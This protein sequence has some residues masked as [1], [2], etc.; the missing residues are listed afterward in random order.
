[1][2]ANTTST[3][4][5]FT[6]G[7]IVLPVTTGPAVTIP[8]TILNPIR[9]PII[10]RPQN[11][12]PAWF[13]SA[14][15]FL[16]QQYA[17][18]SNFV[19]EF[20]SYLVGS[21]VDPYASLGSTR[22]FII[23]LTRNIFRL[24]I[25]PDIN[26]L[27]S[28]NL[29][30]ST[31]YA[32]T[33]SGI[34]SMYQALAAS[35]I[36]SSVKFCYIPGFL[37]KGLNP[38]ADQTRSLD[39]GYDPGSGLRTCVLGSA[40]SQ[41]V[42]L[43]DFST[44][45]NEEIF[46]PSPTIVPFV[47]ALVYDVNTNNSLNAKT[48]V[49]PTYYT[50][51][52]I[53]SNYYVNKLGSNQSLNG[54]SVNCGQTVLF[55]GGPG[56]VA[57]NAVS[58]TLQ[59]TT[60]VT[61]VDYTSTTYVFSTATVVTTSTSTLSP[62]V[63]LGVLSLTY[64]GSSPSTVFSNQNITGFYQDSTWSTCRGI[65][66][67]DFG[68]QNASFAPSLQT[69][70][71][72]P[73]ALIYDPTSPFL[74]GGP[75]PLVL[76]KIFI[77][78]Y[79]YPPDR[80]VQ[81]L[82]QAATS[83]SDTRAAA[84]GLAVQTAALDF[85]LTSTPTGPILDHLTVP[86]SVTVV[87]TP[88]PI[89]IPIR[90]LDDLKSTTA[91]SVKVPTI[92]VDS[93][94]YITQLGPSTVQ[95]GLNASIPVEAL[96]GTG[97]TT[98]EIGTRFLQQPLGQGSAIE[99]ISAAGAVINL[100]KDTDVSPF[101]PY[102]LSIANASTRFSVGVYY[103]LS[104]SGANLTVR[105]SDGSSVS[106][107]ISSPP[108][109]GHTYVG[110]VVYASSITAVVLYAKLQ[111]TLLSPAVG[112]HG[113]LQDTK[114]SVHLI[115][116]QGN[117]TYDIVDSTLATV[118][119]SI[120]VPSPQATDGS[121]PL[122]N[123]LYFGSFVGGSSQMTV[124]SVPV[125]LT[126][127]PS[128][129]S[130]ASF[131]GGMVL[132]SVASGLPS[133]Q[134]QITDSSLFI[135]SNIN[136]DSESIGS[137]SSSNV[138]LAS[139]VINS[140]PDDRSAQAYAPNKLLMGLVRQAQVGSNN[141]YVFVPED[142]SVVI[143]GIRYM[144]S[145]ISLGEVP[146]FSTLQYPLPYLPVYWP[147]AQY[148]QF[149]SKHNPY[150]DVQYTGSTQNERIRTAQTDTIRIGL[151]TANAQEPIHMYLDTDPTLM[152]VYPI[153]AFPFLKATN[154]IDIGQLS[155]ITSTI[156]KILSTTFPP[157]TPFVPSNLDKERI[158]I[159]DNL[160]L[161]NPYI[162]D[163][164]TTIVTNPPTTDT[165]SITA[166]D[167]T[168]VIVGLQVSNLA[169]NTL[170]QT[171][172]NT[173]QAQQN[174][175]TK[176][177]QTTAANQAV[178]KITTSVPNVTQ[179]LDLVP[180]KLLNNSFRHA[181]QPV[182]G[183]SVYNAGSGEAY[184]IEVVTSNDSIPDVLPHP[185]ANANYDPYYV[186]VVFLN[187]LTAYNMSIIVPSMVYDENNV[188]ATQGVT[189]QNVLSQTDEFP[190]GYVS[191][192]YD[193]N[194]NFDTLSF[195]PYPPVANPIFGG[196]DI[197]L[198]FHLSQ[199]Q[200][201]LF[202]STPYSLGQLAIYNP[203]SLFENV[204]SQ[205]PATENSRLENFINL[206][207]IQFIRP[208]TPPAYFVCRR[209]NWKSEC[210]LMQA[211]HN[212]G[213]AAY[214][215]F[216]AGDIVP[217][218]LTSPSPISI[219]HRLPAFNR[220]LTFPFA[221]KQYVAAQV[222]SVGNVP[223]VIASSTDGTAVQFS[224]F[225]LSSTDGTLDVSNTNK[226]VLS[227]PSEIY[228]VGQA[229]T[230][231]T[232]VP[233][234]TGVFNLPDLNGNLSAF[235]VVT[236]NNLVYL[237]RAVSNIPPQYGL[238]AIGGIG[239]FAGLLIDTY[240][241][242]ID[243]ALGL[244]QGA[245]HKRSGLSFFGSMYTPTTMVES[246]D[247]LDYT[248]ITGNTFYA[249]TMFI[250]IPE[251]DSMKGFVADLSNFLGQQVWTFIYPEIV[252]L[253]GDS[254]NGVT[255]KDGYN[256]DNNKKPILSLQKLHF[257]YDSIAV[258]FTSNDLTHKYTLQP[259]QQVLALTNDQII[260]GI[261]WRSANVQVD[262]DP[263]TNVCA[264]QILSTGIGYDRPNIIYSPVN[265]P[266]A[267]SA[268]PSYQG[269]SV[270][271]F[272][273]MSGTTYN[274]EERKLATKLSGPPPDQ[275]GAKYINSVSSTKNM[276]IGVLFDYDNNDQGTMTTYDSGTSTKGLAFLNGYQSSNGYTFSS[277]DHFDVND[278]LKSQ[279]PLLEEI[280]NNMQQDQAFFNTDL[281]LPRQYWSLTYDVFTAAGLPNYIATAPP[282]LIDPNFTN[283]T[284]S[285]ILSLQN[286]QDPVQP[287]EI[288]L[289]DT[290]SSVVSVNLHLQNGIT[291]SIFLNKTADRDIAY[292]SSPSVPTGSVPPPT[293]WIGSIFGLPANYDFF[294]FSRDHYSTLYGAA[295]QVIDNGYAMCLMD[296]GTGTGNK[297]AKYYVDS[298]GNYFESYS[299]VLSSLSNGIVETSSFILKVTLGSPANLAATP[300]IPETPNNISPQDMVNAI[301][302]ASNVVY[303]A[304]GP[305]S[306]GQPPAYI[307][308][309]AVGTQP[310]ALPII[311]PPGFNGYQ[312]NVSAANRQPVQISQIYSGA[313]AYPI[314]GSTA[315][316]PLN[317]A[318]NFVPFYGS[319][320]H[321]LD[322]Q[323]TVFKSLQ[324]ADPYSFIPRGAIP[325]P[326]VVGGAGTGSLIG[327]EFRLC[328]QG[329]AAIPPT[330]S[331]ST[332]AG[333][334]ME[335][336]DA[337]FYTYNAV[338]ATIF[339]S[340]GKS[341]SVSGGQYFV[342]TVTTQEPIY[343]AITLPT[344]TFNGNTYTVNI[345]TT[346]MDGVTSLYTLVVG[347]KS[348]L[349]DSGNK[350]VTTDQTKFT[351]N[352]VTSGA[353]TVTYT[354]IDTPSGNIST[355]PTP[356]LLSPF[357]VTG[358]GRVGGLVVDVFNSPGQ[359]QN[360]I[361]GITGR[362]YSYDPVHA[363]VTITQGSTATTVP[364]STGSI[365]ASS[366]GYGYVIQFTTVPNVAGQ[367][368]AVNGAIMFKY[369][370]ML[371]SSP[372]PYNLMTTPKMFTV[373]GDHYTFD[374]DSAGNYLT[375]TGNNQTI[376]VNPYQFSILGEIYIINTQTTPN[377]VIGGGQTYKMTASNTQ[378]I[379]NGVQYTIS[380]LKN[381]LNGATISGQFNISQGNVIV[382]EDFVYQLDTLNGQIVGNGATY[383]LVSGGNTYT[384]T[385][386]GYVDQNF[387]VTTQ[388]N[389]TTV[390][391]GN[392]VYSIGDATVVGDEITYP[393]LPYR[394]FVDGSNKFNIELDGTVSVAPPLALTAKPPP[395]PRSTFS[396]GS[397][398]YTVNDIAAY[399][400]SNYFLISGSPPQFSTT[401]LKYTIRSDGVAIAAGVS[402]TY[403]VKTS[404]PLSPNQFTFGS[405][406][407]S[408]GQASD[409]AAFDGR[410][411]HA[412]TNNQFTDSSTGLTYTISGNTAVNAGNSFEI[413]SNLGQ[414]PYFEV[415]NGPTYYIGINVAETGSATGDVYNVFPISGG[416]FTIP[417]VYQ[418]TITGS[419][420]SV[421]SFTLSGT[422]STLTANGG[423]L[424]GGYFVDPV[425][426]IT[427]NC[428]LDYP[429]I[430]FADSNNAVYEYPA[431]ST[432]NTFV[433]DV[434]VST[435][436]SLAVDNE[437]TPQVYPIMNNQF[438]VNP[439]MTY[440]I[441]VPV[442]YT[443]A[444]TGPYWP[445]VNGRFVVPAVAPIFNIAY[446]IH[447]SSVTKGYVINQDDQ[448]SVDGNAV[449]TINAVNVVKVT[450]QA[451]LTGAPPNQTL[452]VGSSTYTLNSITFVAS[453]QPTGL[454]FNSTTKQFTVSY[455]G[456]I[457]VTYTVGA[458]SG[459]T[460]SVTDNRNP[461]NTF[462]YPASGTQVTFNDA[463]G[464][465]TFTFNSAGNSVIFAQF[466]YENNF[467]TDSISG[468]TYYID[469]PDNKVEGIS[470]LPETTQNA[471]V[472]AD[473]HTYLIHYSDV[474][475]IFPIISGPN[476]NV[477]V[478]TV[479]SGEF[480]VHVD[481][482]TSSDSGIP[483]NT[484]LN[485][486]EIN[487]NLYTI[488]GNAQG[489]DYSKCTIVGANVA[490]RLF[491]GK[492]TFMLTDPT[493]TYTLQLDASN[494]PIAVE[495]DFV[496]KPSQDLVI[497]NE[498]VYVISYNS[499]SSGSL[500]GQG[501]P[502]IPI[503]D[504][505]FTL[506][507]NFDSTV[508]KFVFAD[509]NIYDAASVIGQFTVY[510]NPT[511][512]IGSTTY[513]L[514]TNKLVVVDNDKRPFPLISN[515]TMF[516]IN[517]FNYVIDTNRTPHA[518]IGNSN[519]S[520]LQ[521]DVTVQKGK[522]IANTTFTLNGMVLKYTEDLLQTLLNVTETQSYMIA[523]PE[524][525]F[526]LGSGLLFTISTKAPAAGS[527]P[528]SV[529]PT[530]SLTAGGTTLYIFAGVPESG[531]AD[532]FTYQNVMYTLVKSNGVYEAAQK[533]YTVYA[534]YPTPAQQQLAVFNIAGTTYMVTDGTT[535][536]TSLSAGINPGTLWAATAPTSSEAQFGLVYG[537]G[538]QPITVTRSS[539][540]PNN[541]QFQVTDSSGNI[542]VYDILY[543]AKAANNTVQIDVPQDL[544][545]F[546]Q[547]FNFSQSSPLVLETGGYNAFN[548]TVDES[549]QPLETFSAAYKSAITSSDPQ[550]DSLITAQGDFSV[551]FWHSLPVTSSNLADC[552]GITYNAS[553]DNQSVYFIDVGIQSPAGIY[554][555]VN[556]TL[557]AANPN[558]PVFSSRWR[559]L[560]VTYTQPYVMLCQ[561]AGF[562]VKQN[563]TN[564]NVNQ[565]FSI[566]MT[567]SVQDISF[568]QGLLYKGNGTAPAAGWSYRVGVIGGAVTLAFI[569]GNGTKQTFTGPTISTG[570][571]YRLI[572]T[573]NTYNPVSASNQNSSTG[574]TD[575][576]LPPF[577]SKD[578]AKAGGSGALTIGTP[579]TISG[580][581]TTG[582]SPNAQ[583]FVDNLQSTSAPTKSYTIII[584]VQPMGDDWKPG[585][586]T[587]SPNQ[588]L[589]EPSGGTDSLGLQV[590][591][592]GT[593]SLY[594]G[595]AFD[596][597]AQQLPLGA[598]GVGPNN[599]GSSTGNISDV[600][601]FNAAIDPTNFDTISST[602]A[603]LLGASVLGYWKAA[604]DPN[605]IVN[606]G[607]D[608]TAIAVSDN[609]SMAYLAPQ[610]SRELEGTS[611]WVN[612]YP[613]PLAPVGYVIPSAGS[614]S[615]GSSQL[616]FNSGN[617]NQYTI[618]EIS[619][620]NACRQQYQI[621]ND[622][623]GRLVVSNE[624][625]L[626]LYLSSSFTAKS[627]GPLL[628]MNQYI[629][630]IDVN[631]A[632]G[633]PQLQFAQA[634]QSL[635][636]V[637]PVARCGPLVTP[638]LYT[639]PGVAL[640]VADTVPSMTTYSVTINNTTS[641]LAGELNEAYVYISNK[642]L[643]LY[644]GKKV[645][646]LV[647]SWVSQEQ[648][649][650]QV[651][652]YI[653]GAPPAPMANL[654]NK[655]SY[656]GA[657]TLT[658]SAQVS[659]A[660]NYEQENDHSIDNTLSLEAKVVDL[661]EEIKMH[662]S[663]FGFGIDLPLLK[664]KLG[665]SGKFEWVQSSAS[666]TDTTSTNKLTETNTYV[667]KM[668]G[669]LAPTNGDL[670]MSN[671]NALTTPSTTGNPATTT[672]I[673]PN[674]DLG[675]FTASNPPTALPTK[676][677][678]DEKFGS[679]VFIPSPY[680]QA[681]VTSTLLD[682]YQQTLLQSGAVYGFVSVP[683]TQVPPDLNIVPFRISSKYIRPGCL[684][685]V[686]GY[687]YKPATLS[688]GLQTYTTSTGEMQVLYDK[689]FSQDLVGH[690]A[691]YMKLVE[692]YQLKKQIDQEA[693]NALALYQSTYKATG[694]PSDPQLT[695]GLDFYNEYIWNSSGASQEVKHSYS[696]TF[697]QVQTTTSGFALNPD[698]SASISVKLEGEAVVSVELDEK[699]SYKQSTKSSFKQTGTAAFDITAS[700]D[701]LENDT[702]MRYASNNDAH[703]VM[704]NN[705]MFNTSNNSGL[706][707]VIGSDGRVFNIV[708]SVSSGAGLPLSDNVDDSM[709]YTQPQP[710][711]TSGNANGSTG[712]LE[713]YDRPGKTSS[714][715]S[716]AFFLQPSAEN[717]QNFWNTVVDST[718]LANSPEAGAAAL[719]TAQPPNTTSIPWR[720][721]YRVTDSERFLPP[722]SNDIPVTPS[723][724]P[725]MAV[726]VT[727]AATDFLF[728]NINNTGTR[729]SSNPANDIDANIVL[730]SPSA[731]GLSVGS[732]PTTG[733][734]KGTTVL[735]NNVIPF[736]LVNLSSNPIPNWG[737]RNNSALLSKLLRSVLGL[738]TMTISNYV[739]P[740][741]TEKAVIMDPIS[742]GVLYTVYTDPNGYTV[743]VATNSSITVYQDVNSNPVQYYDGK[744]Y[745]SLQADYIASQDGTLMVYIQPPANYDQSTFNMT[746]DYDL[747]G[748]PGDEW[749]YYYVSAYS[750]DMTSSPTVS[751]AGPFRSSGG[752]T[753][754]IG[755]TIPSAQHVS[756]SNNSDSQVAGYVLCQ[757]T[758][759]WPSLNTSA[760]TFADILVYKA[761][762]LLD[763]FPIGDVGALMSFLKAQY[764]NASFVTA[765]TENDE[766][767]LVFARNIF[768]YFNAAQQLL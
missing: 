684:D 33:D 267:T 347:G 234:T 450:N 291:G 481:S 92:G 491:T 691:S 40:V 201:K 225:S 106:T 55:P 664:F 668:E 688:N 429:N 728:M 328:F 448:F 198:I 118:A 107:T 73:P 301:N 76:Q 614:H 259:K 490:P 487:G 122:V 587:Y 51:D 179:E 77:A 466:L 350:T 275:S 369:P 41:V 694:S 292:L 755:F 653:E 4:A 415:P 63:Q 260:E 269:M 690:D 211:T 722:I 321:G 616:S 100:T 44:T 67:Y 117:S 376:P 557:M 288:G 334:T 123:D 280:A 589:N 710:A 613:V 469:V 673:L 524:M 164:N 478:A 686:I 534:A 14:L 171:V 377:T 261:C 149:A 526:K 128:Q 446:T 58:L 346:E 711:Y 456:G 433:A 604:Y 738:N 538:S 665:L 193:S 323:V 619:M 110:A 406:T 217:F 158:T 168:P 83:P 414:T 657:T 137:I 457:L 363:T 586:L 148:W 474:G 593:G 90:R 519:V 508:A 588:Y 21:D 532:F 464:N 430:T 278:V 537:F 194:N 459:S 497:V 340:T 758:M 645:G 477:G 685:G 510:L 752:A 720:V 453:I 345:N 410:N 197:G 191:S 241:P 210:H 544:P 341:G 612:G 705:S 156:L 199:S 404:G 514:D 154:T 119:S 286:L 572:I 419:T 141:T 398:S 520:P 386:T 332:P 500:L 93:A 671:L 331:G 272:L 249:P 314:V 257:V 29:S 264:Q 539:V 178:T 763:T 417:L 39:I 468:T 692:T 746:G 312:L 559:H 88:P 27:A 70:P 621:M 488:Q 135:Y 152:T 176:Q 287:T 43:N 203:I 85:N 11:F 596:D 599:A 569:D 493:V 20:N 1:M 299:Y 643:N 116:G 69:A 521:T 598:P 223:Y 251:L 389:A 111:L 190:L 679:L 151:N 364:V 503:S 632:L 48:F 146:D 553:T 315:T 3:P 552:H 281:S 620:W 167:T 651:V 357:T 196:I 81:I 115:Y 356:I 518:I 698:T 733:P 226:Q 753:P 571:P 61:S 188:L 16:G 431:P 470:Y 143:G 180:R 554:I 403:I 351:F 344:F 608:S 582:L 716:Y 243:G 706:N 309:Q 366:S 549:I 258:L 327:T 348:Y 592:T 265:R 637:P 181:F 507:N 636:F 492:N 737:D 56:Y 129:L 124:W 22:L 87:T 72:A 394:T 49:L 242:T 674:P 120:T 421:S 551:E 708:P 18:G 531:N 467:F 205:Q 313:V 8:T 355:T 736:D 412:I 42:P 2:S 105:G 751:D 228:V 365:F 424:T 166:V 144:L 392:I 422:I 484:N 749:R 566:V 330:T 38:S 177:Q 611:L 337:V 594:I 185:T 506:N 358:G 271:S 157:N 655:P 648:G 353:Y 700:Y 262:R 666:T 104:L 381:S 126:V 317:Q 568:D 732:T 235:Q 561:G 558:P 451:T 696:T 233:N 74:N 379:I 547:Q 382:I 726:P 372:V 375:V 640:T 408:Y 472:A 565:D 405:K 253:P 342:D 294:V 160:T 388:P 649:N 527:Y 218:R 296:D 349:F 359:L 380:L 131:N 244:A 159:P 762:S 37:S 486:F 715:R 656:A 109:A 603:N 426:K 725:V 741:S 215:A 576:Y 316:Q 743:N 400:G 12:A 248:S 444:T 136:V 101:P 60:P 6:P 734:L 71:L 476:V 423:S 676:P 650:V 195:S 462:Q 17:D 324:S 153:Y 169:P 409:H 25:A 174:L 277:G 584:A 273:S 97:I 256:V 729:P 440:A 65:P 263:P 615:S 183:F 140:S 402:Q 548:T 581:T 436:V 306:S 662:I 212:T 202:T 693:F 513:T 10:F 53:G 221:D 36:F 416:Q 338:S 712:A 541:F 473:G 516:S 560:A 675:G 78:K 447:G 680:G 68:S 577:G 494:L 216:G 724:S 189:Y 236:Y 139:A 362:Q 495:A 220:E 383:P 626:A 7:R 641:N 742:G 658:F 579:A 765:A 460:G 224:S 192:L 15:N 319:I 512:V 745:H 62:K 385:T 542:T 145:I 575:P 418:F 335:A 750:S 555:K 644:A 112:T 458:V 279:L 719:R 509:L 454:V 511:F 595:N 360:M 232:P 638:N 30:A 727:N 536:G 689:N 187:T 64:T 82:N 463:V 28:A 407:I 387:T 318:G 276:L 125:F 669:S 311:G 622:M 744:T 326:L 47:V 266:V 200:L 5:A 155:T 606:N 163:S 578:V 182:Y 601:I 628:P 483:I 504:S 173:L 91:A 629:D 303:A 95:L 35:S 610:K 764:P 760:E 435:G 390:T 707:L 237:I 639:P 443:N 175:Q 759:Q 703:F 54:A 79:L 270:N 295:L 642:V 274:V 86:V 567:F 130:G 368:Y 699:F 562:E 659:E 670:F 543:T 370:G 471:F 739:A 627:A 80:L 13:Y 396:D 545:S 52:L 756:G 634:S 19:Q 718:W 556:E 320:S 374:Q 222:I 635:V 23:A 352:P 721:L 678:T 401:S 540:S 46:N 99:Q 631:N 170:P 525:T 75:L 585:A 367:V 411:Y 475:V 397:T 702:Q 607:F 663:P 432:T 96:A 336:D 731:S 329:S 501:E 723:I 102:S 393:I 434:V 546:T 573:K 391:I 308:I 172:A 354:A 284:R 502:S 57:A 113:V 452:T 165:S 227:F 602:N 207:S 108:A 564:L 50:P 204:I 652:G 682:V 289:M 94:A 420:V 550:I 748:H 530:G 239:A 268:I 625:T 213:S 219:D 529:A 186:R 660:L 714:F 26:S 121:R 618:T 305:V 142:D 230:T 681:F 695:P 255:Y 378:F 339:D 31:S 103:V 597:S 206:S 600:Y 290:F 439:T 293:P 89:Y 528:G 282:S 437:S 127:G 132:E 455:S 609:A 583:A 114:Y 465:V 709:T 162:A 683:N 250:P 32:N 298:D 461:Q 624:P 45:S 229:S 580:V 134:L 661:D 677:P 246:L 735:P 633:L 499:V 570:Q 245:R 371:S 247:N 591:N 59:S 761:M 563:A 304:F 138:Y 161:N 505:S 713:P 687:T 240:V 523:Q 395:D 283:R 605:G 307:P 757:G 672:A 34:L 701:G 630:S 747:F 646:D 438:S 150:L 24:S 310:Q 485:S 442:A 252:A 515:P 522:P 254:V 238:N 413:F 300:V 654:T 147:S 754:F 66:M 325:P 209:L 231:L 285:L 184:I 667:V 489:N 333:S 343:V 517:G 214:L 767:S 717:G 297:V 449:Y 766:I 740:G 361:L 730:V 535:A 384:I 704:R 482:V 590:N 427:Y 533:S 574:A 768:S 425:T 322:S 9:N 428:V 480:F 373:G 479:G 498:N 647:L 98:I 445:I 441:Q 697:D 496:V 617:S 84:A 399:D 302:K 623:F 208:R 133:Y